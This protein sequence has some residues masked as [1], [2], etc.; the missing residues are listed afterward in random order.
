MMQKLNHA[1]Q[2]AKRK[3]T[4]QTRRIKGEPYV[5]H[6]KRVAYTVSFYTEKLDVIIAALLHDT[7]EDTPTRR[8]ELG[9]EFG[10]EVA[11]LVYA[12]TNDTEEMKRLGGKRAYLAQKINTLSLDELLIKLAD[13]VDNVQDLSHD[14]W[15][16]KYCEETRYVFLNTLDRTGLTGAHLDLLGRIQRQVIQCESR[17]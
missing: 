17:S 2:F 14:A 3:H 7:L 13:R 9:A 11:N 10:T 16:R 5:E 8:E 15:S 1:L 12:L 4:G 6:C